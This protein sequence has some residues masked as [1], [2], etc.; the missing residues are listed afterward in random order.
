MTSEAAFKRIFFRDLFDKNK[1]T[2]EWQIIEELHYSKEGHQTWD[3]LVVLFYFLVDE[4]IYPVQISDHFELFDSLSRYIV[5]SCINHIGRK[6][7]KSFQ[8]P[9]KYLAFNVL[10][11]AVC[12]NLSPEHIEFIE[13]NP[14]IKKQFLEGSLYSR[15]ENQRAEYSPY[16]L[17]VKDFFFEP[18]QKV[19]TNDCLVHAMNYALRYPFFT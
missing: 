16:K 13:K 15:Q 11:G 14:E 1:Q 6:E 5:M 2:M 18:L 3:H 7:G 10:A 8:I 12:V 4:A 9:R 19:Y 17:L